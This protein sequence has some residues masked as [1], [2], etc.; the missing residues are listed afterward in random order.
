MNKKNRKPGKFKSKG[1]TILKAQKSGPNSMNEFLEDKPE[2]IAQIQKGS[3]AQLCKST[4]PQNH[5]FTSVQSRKDAKTKISFDENKHSATKNI[6]LEAVERIHVQ[7]RKDL[8]DKLIET[9]YA[10]KRD[11]KVKKRNASQRQ[12]IEQALEEYFAK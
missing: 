5:N 2:K 11:G 7:I 10:R 1:S 9:V 8:A 4:D 3:V 6:E 12:I